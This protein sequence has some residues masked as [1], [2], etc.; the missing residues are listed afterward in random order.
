MAESFD[1]SPSASIASVLARHQSSLLAFIR[2]NASA[3]ILALESASDILQSTLLGLTRRQLSFEFRGEASL[4][5]WLHVA[6]LRKIQD[7]AKFHGRKRRSAGLVDIST[8]SNTQLLSIY[9]QVFSPS[10]EVSAQ[11]EVL[12][13]ERIFQQLEPTDR[14]VITLARFAELDYA[15]IAAQQRRSPD[16]V[17]MHLHRA[18]AR[19]SRLLVEISPSPPE[20]RE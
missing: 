17:R 14:E 15:E 5:K 2:L 12:R 11:E 7:R 10:M 9:R 8:A 1:R 6:V 13:I 4:L 16:A 20:Q 19:L 18:L 3:R